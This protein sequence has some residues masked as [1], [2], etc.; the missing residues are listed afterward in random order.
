MASKALPGLLSAYI[1]PWHD[2]SGSHVPCLTAWSNMRKDFQP[3]NSQ[4]LAI[5]II[6]YLFDVW[7][8]MFNNRKEVARHFVSSFII[9]IPR[10]ITVWVL[11]HRMGRAV[12]M[13]QI[14]VCNNELL[15][16]GWKG[17]ILLAGCP[18]LSSHSPSW[19]PQGGKTVGMTDWPE[20][21][22]RGNFPHKR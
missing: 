19:S 7:C 16:C 5:W 17:F 13:G 18:Q 12:V 15:L 1:Y 9:E 6:E 8:F 4:M 10:L 22:K 20:S 21:R 2:G 14:R 3:L 11:F